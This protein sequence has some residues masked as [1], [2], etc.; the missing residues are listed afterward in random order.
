M[1]ETRHESRGLEGKREDEAREQRKR[2]AENESKTE[3][4]GRLRWRDIAI[5]VMA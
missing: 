3:G 2:I 4:S 1:K 5:V